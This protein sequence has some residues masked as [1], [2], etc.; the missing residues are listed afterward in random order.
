MYFGHL[1]DSRIYYFPKDGEMTQVSHDHSH[2]GCSAAPARSMS[3]RRGRIP[4]G[5]CSSKRWGRGIN[6]SILK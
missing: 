4:A 1:G 3:G 6:C 2:V 5:M